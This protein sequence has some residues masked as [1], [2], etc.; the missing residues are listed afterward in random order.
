MEVAA[1]AES[2]FWTFVSTSWL[3]YHQLKRP[4]RRYCTLH[5]CCS[6]RIVVA[7][8][9]LTKKC[10]ID[11]SQKS[12]NLGNHLVLRVGVIPCVAGV[13]GVDPA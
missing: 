8:P 5:H 9:V 7:V 13:S 3:G 6:R 10:L 11:A 2:S 12:Q 1:A 4:R